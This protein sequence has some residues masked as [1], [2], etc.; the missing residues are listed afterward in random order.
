[1][2]NTDLQRA[3]AAEQRLSD[4]LEAIRN[5]CKT[6]RHSA[7]STNDFSGDIDWEAETEGQWLPVNDVLALAGGGHP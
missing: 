7:Y 4:L 2:Y 1:M 5:V 6:R 3:L